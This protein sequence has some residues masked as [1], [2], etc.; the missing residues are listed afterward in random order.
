M[1]LSRSL[2]F[3]RNLYFTTKVVHFAGYIY[4]SRVEFPARRPCALTLRVRGVSGLPFPSSIVE[5]P[6]R[7]CALCC[8]QITRVYDSV[9]TDPPT[10]QRS[11]RPQKGHFRT[12]GRTNFLVPPTR[13]TWPHS[14]SIRRYFNTISLVSYVFINYL[15]SMWDMSSR[16]LPR[17]SIVELWSYYYSAV[18]KHVCELMM[19]VG[20]QYILFMFVFFPVHP[21]CFVRVF[22]YIL[23]YLWYGI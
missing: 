22:I 9:V 20:L 11:T 2:Y 3:R 14:F 1:L 7:V 12:K 23:I 16:R 17:Y 15:S 19:C 10:M 4:T 5:T 13:V 18:K 6:T 21:F 8:Q